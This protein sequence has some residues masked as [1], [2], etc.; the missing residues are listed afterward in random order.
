MDR[1]QIW[2]RDRDSDVKALVC[3]DWFYGQH[4]SKERLELFLWYARA[5]E[6]EYPDDIQMLLWY[7]GGLYGLRNYDD[8]QFVSAGTFDF[9]RAFE[10][11]A[12]ALWV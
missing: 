12:V 4:L 8:W 2:Y 9:S 7:V 11:L 5:E 3:I 6:D 1:E 10:G